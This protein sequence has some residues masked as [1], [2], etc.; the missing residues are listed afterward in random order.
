MQHQIFFILK[1]FFC[2]FVAYFLI[3][4]LNMPI[5]SSHKILVGEVQEG[6]APTSFIML[7]VVLYPSCSVL[8]TM[9]QFIKSCVYRSKMMM[10]MI[11][12]TTL[13]LLLP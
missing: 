3:N 10:M 1:Q 11:P 7:R 6:N 2:L 12:W 8:G 13:L 5:D 9:M 4:F